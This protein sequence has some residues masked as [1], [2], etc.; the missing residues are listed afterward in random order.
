MPEVHSDRVFKDD[1]LPIHSQKADEEEEE[2]D[3]SGEERALLSNSQKG[4]IIQND[5]HLTWSKWRRGLVVCVL[6]LAQAVMTSA[7]S[8]VGPFFPLQVYILSERGW[9]V[10]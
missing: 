8:L 2:E 7:Y 4:D 3:E 9:E 5:T 10:V 1:R 6:W